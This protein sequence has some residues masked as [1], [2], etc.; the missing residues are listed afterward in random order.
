MDL[1]GSSVYKLAFAHTASKTDAEDIYQEVFVR[2][3]KDKTCFNDDEHLKAWLLKVTMNCCRDLARL[4]WKRK[5]SMMDDFENTREAVVEEDVGTVHDL[6]KALE[7][8]PEAMRSV[9]HLYYYEDYSAEEIAKLL[10]INPSTVRTRLQR[11]RGKLKTL[12]GGVENDTIKY[13]YEN[14]GPSGAVCR[15]EG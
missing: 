5:V 15:S 7:S 2:L 1:W 9:V 10:G 4:G 14:D 13:V 11:A 8:L 3:F 12:L 6:V